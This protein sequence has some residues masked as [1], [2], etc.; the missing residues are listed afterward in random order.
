MNLIDWS[1]NAD[2]LM[3]QIS[4][5]STKKIVKILGLEWDLKEDLLKLNF[6]TSLDAQNKRE[7]LKVIA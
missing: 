6:K 3:S 4:N 1:S 7:V 5:S 2:K